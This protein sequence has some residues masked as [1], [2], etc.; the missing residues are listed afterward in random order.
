VAVA[1]PALDSLQ[2]QGIYFAPLRHH[3]PA[4]AWAVRAMLHELRPSAVLVEGP[5]SFN[6]LLPLLLDPACQPPLAVLCQADAGGESPASAFFPFCDYSP[7]WV[8]LR[9][10]QE[11]GA[12]LA[13]IDL[14][15]ADKA[16]LRG[17][18]EDE[19]H[20]LMAERYFQHSRHIDEL[21]ARVG[22]R[23]HNE[24]WDHLFELRPPAALADWR[25]LF[26]DVYHYCAET[27]VDYEL[28]VLEGD[29]S[30]PRERHMAAHIRHWRKQTQGNIVVLTGGF[31]TPALL[32][33]CASG[34]SSAP[35]GA[36]AQDWLIRYSFD[37]LDALNGYGAGMP[38]P[39]YYQRVWEA[40]Q[41]GDRE[42]QRSVTLDCLGGIA[43]QYSDLGLVE[44]IGTADV[45]AAALQAMR[46]ADLRGHP[47]P[48]RHDL[49]DAM[50]SCFIKGA[51]GESAHGLPDILR[52]YLGG[53]RLGQ[54]PAS[55]GAPPLLEDG[56]RLARQ[57][58]IRLDD[59]QPRNS[60]LEIYRKPAHRL[61]SRFLHLMRYLDCGLGRQVSGPD[62]LA[63]TRLDMMVE[64]WEVAWTPLVEAR[65]VELA[66]QGSTLQEV[67]LRR[68]REQETALGAAGQAQS[69]GRAVGLL[70][71]AAAVGLHE[72]L[73]A[74]LDLLSHHLEAD[75]SFVSVV[76]CARQL[77]TLWRAREP[78]GMQGQPGLGRL[79]QSCWPAALF[80][81]PALAGCK[82]E[83]EAALVDAVLALR[84]FG[85]SEYRRGGA[86]DEPLQQ[87]HGLLGGM[88]ARKGC[89]PGIAGA[90]AAI[91]Y[92]DA[93]WDQQQLA[94]AA[95]RRFGPGAQPVDAVRFLSGLMA[96][97]PELLVTQP[98]LLQALDQVMDGWD[99][100]DFMR[101]LPELRRAFSALKPV[102]TS[103]VARLLAQGLGVEA[104]ELQT[105]SAVLSEAD[106]LAGAELQSL[107]RAGL[108]RDGLQSWLEGKVAA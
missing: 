61:R 40:L 98:A 68:L 35:R 106:M 60:R 53:S 92:L 23:D 52:R 17:R 54:V 3:S 48:G 59:A 21:A 99:E 43:Q 45:Q 15:W 93:A 83:E 37:Q 31:H 89:A 26:R 67:A 20:S 62:Y 94:Q 11:L 32:G 36:A 51:L 7:E 87:L 29:G 72:R 71:Q 38:A 1:Y 63:G 18:G 86:G 5:D 77:Q 100:R 65:L 16:Q 105:A 49:M 19:D 6:P 42:P 91:L 44:R 88:A 56:R 41:S 39:A 22:C 58:R 30:L 14:P 80:L 95:A 4:C 34:G 2:A 66:S 70:V 101:C 10:G 82:E 96:A 50:Q 24:L 84:E 13:F 27:R 55:A 8:G 12:Q 47:G 75:A 25:S 108:E 85:R 79:M 90:A 78:L 69:A 103:D 104:G 9:T 57:C 28:E 74:L 64:E 102:E 76:Q 46:L 97:A 73:P 81:L 107:L 33:L